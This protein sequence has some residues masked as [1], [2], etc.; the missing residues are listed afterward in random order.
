MKKAMLW[1]VGVLGGLVAL[2]AILPEPEPEPD[3]G[4]VSAATWDGEWPFTVDSGRVYCGVPGNPQFLHVERAAYL[5]HAA[6]FVEPG[7][8]GNWW[9]LNGLARD[10]V[11]Q[12]RNARFKDD[13]N[14]LLAHP[15][16]YPLD[17]ESGSPEFERESAALNAI[18]NLQKAALALCD[19]SEPA[20]SEPDFPPEPIDPTRAGAFDCQLAV[21]RL[22]QYSVRWTD[23]FLQPK[24]TRYEWKGEHVANIAGDSVEFQNGFG[25]WQPHIYMCTVDFS[26]GRDQPTVVDAVA[27]PGRLP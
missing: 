2:G 7:P 4:A 3:A 16:S 13:S 5:S 15:L 27:T 26:R 18:G 6:W 22:A 8:D 19:A 14:D 25:A 1:T 12:A 17:S 11:A 10:W 24:F 20:A 21:E 23:G 9:A